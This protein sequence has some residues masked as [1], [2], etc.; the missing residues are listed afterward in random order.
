MPMKIT[1]TDWGLL[2]HWWSLNFRYAYEP[3]GTACTIDWRDET[4]EFK[5]Y[6]VAYFIG[7]Y[8]LPFSLMLHSFRRIIV[9][10]R[11]YQRNSVRVSQQGIIEKLKWQREED[12]TL[13]SDKDSRFVLYAYGR[14]LHNTCS[15]WFHQHIS[16]FSKFTR[17]C[18]HR[19]SRLFTEVKR[20]VRKPE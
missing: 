14:T 4:F 11:Q 9:L 16:S 13:V 6:I 5:S 3:F 19:L 7:G 18:S 8:V 2:K 20:E 10:K 1:T 15:D 12:L 17:F